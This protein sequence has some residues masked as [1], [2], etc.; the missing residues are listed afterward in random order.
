MVQRFDSVTL[1]Q[2]DDDPGSGQLWIEL[3]ERRYPIEF[4]AWPASTVPVGVALIVTNEVVAPLYADRL[5]SALSSFH[6]KIGVL[7]LPDGEIHKNWESVSKILDSM[8]DIGADR[9]SVIYALGGGVIGDLVGFAAAIYMRGVNFIQVPTTLLAQVDSSVGGKT[10]FN[11]A[12]G[13]NLIGAFH[14]PKSVWMDLTT[15]F[16]LPDREYRAGLA[17]MVKYGPIADPIFFAWLEQ[18]ANALADR[19]LWALGVAVRRSCQI[20]SAIVAADEREEGVRAAL[21]FGHTFGHALEAGLGYG[22]LLHGEAVAMGMVMAV[23]ASIFALGLHDVFL[24]RIQALLLRL[25]LP[26]RAPHLQLDRFIELMIGDKKN[27]DGSIRYVL[28]EGEGRAVLAS[29]PHA[30]ARRAITAHSASD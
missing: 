6:R 16:S 15:L 1:P 7:I 3:K 9:S 26:T 8:I 23:Q 24:D 17:E 22:N 13:K 21:N 30:L 2:F 20:K 4:G 18:N 19:D 11:H 10:G 12:K 27:L 28:L 29:L 25:G 14:Q 5:R